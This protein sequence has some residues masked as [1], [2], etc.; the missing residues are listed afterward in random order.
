M[1]KGQASTIDVRALRNIRSVILDHPNAI[2]HTTDVDQRMINVPFTR[3]GNTLDLQIPGD[4]GLILPG[5]TASGWSTR[6]ARSRRRP[7]PTSVDR[8][9]ASRTTRPA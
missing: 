1:V 5:G 6:R 9:A 4:S 2:T 3:T 8:P 7:G